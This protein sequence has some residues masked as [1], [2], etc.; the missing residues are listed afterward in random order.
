MAPRDDAD[1]VGIGANSH[2]HVAGIDTESYPLRNVGETPREYGKQ[3][4][5]AEKSW[6]EADVTRT[7]SNSVSDLAGC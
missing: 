4:V 7:L 6:N 1:P 3:P 2:S 5:A